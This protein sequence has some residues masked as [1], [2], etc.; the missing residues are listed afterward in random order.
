MKTPISA[1]TLLLCLA[2]L[3][4]VGNSTAQ[5][6]DNKGTDFLIAFMPNVPLENQP[7]TTEIQVT[8]DVP[9]TVQ[10]EYP[11]GTIIDSGVRVSAGNITTLS[12]N[13]TAANDWMPATV[14]SNMIR[15][16][17]ETGDEFIAYTIN[18]KRFTSDAALALPID[19]FNTEFIVSD[20]AVDRS[21]ALALFL[22]YAAFDATTV[23][24][25]PTS[26][27][28]GGQA[29]GVPFDDVLNRGEGYL[30]EGPRSLA[31]SIV[32][33]DKPIGMVNG[34]LCANVPSQFAACDHIYEVAQP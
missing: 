24:I 3:C 32:S 28:T 4:F 31:G 15:V 1:S 23:T 22:V 12:V 19:T 34:H 2:I 26:N 9:L 27:L 33:A 18:R 11:V 6:L 5:S 17:S 25:T 21:D 13:I 10:V 8:S 20:I 14:Q 30:S 7:H 29:A 16:V